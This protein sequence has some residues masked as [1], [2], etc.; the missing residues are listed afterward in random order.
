MFDISVEFQKQR[1]KSSYKNIFDIPAIVGI[2]S[3]NSWAASS[4]DPTGEIKLP[5]QPVLCHSI[6]E[7]EDWFG[8]KIEEGE[9]EGENGPNYPI[10]QS[11]SKIWGEGGEVSKIPIWC[12]QVEG[13]ELT[14]EN[15]QQ[16]LASIR[17]ELLS[18]I[19]ISNYFEGQNEEDLIPLIADFVNE[20]GDC[21]GIFMLP[22]GA[23]SSSYSNRANLVGIGHKRLDSSFDVAS[24]FLGKMLQKPPWQGLSYQFFDS[25]FP[26]RSFS[27]EERRELN[28]NKIT[29]AIELTNGSQMMSKDYMFGPIPSITE[30]RILD[31]AIFRLN[32]FLNSPEVLGNLKINSS[33]LNSIQSRV[34]SA[35]TE[36]VE[37][38]IIKEISVGIPALDAIKVGDLE[39]IQY[40]QRIRKIDI[41]INIK[42]EQIVHQIKIILT[43]T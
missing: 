20:R 15:V 41:F 21:F 24:F 42:I 14:V 34:S 3:P 2:G 17:N 40:Y 7:V 27:T 32:L 1:K 11:A 12:V 26:S 13:D 37:S 35:L 29:H 9:I 19:L 33:G 23:T 4:T 5:F 28:Q 22:Y 10:Y 38:G 18:V 8:D 16:A 39:S 25:S 30:K 31:S 6:G 36:F 43:L